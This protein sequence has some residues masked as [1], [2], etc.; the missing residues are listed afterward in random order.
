MF[1]HAI[2][3]YSQDDFNDENIDDDDVNDTLGG[4]SS[5]IGDVSNQSVRELVKK[6]PF[7]VDKVFKPGTKSHRKPYTKRPHLENP[8]KL[9]PQGNDSCEP[10]VRHDEDY[11]DGGRSKSPAVLKTNSVYKNS[12]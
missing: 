1:K 9:I 7:H 8:Q 3:D 6:N 5:H 11:A 4:A 2:I 10:K 12:E